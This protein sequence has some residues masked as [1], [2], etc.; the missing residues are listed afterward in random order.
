MSGELNE[1]FLDSQLLQLTLDEKREALANISRRKTNSPAAHSNPLTPVTKSRRNES[2][3]NK[4]QRE[5]LSGDYLPGRG[6]LPSKLLDEELDAIIEEHESDDKKCDHKSF[7]AAP[8]LS[9]LQSTGYGKTRAMVELAKTSDKRVVY[10]LCKSLAQSWR[11]PQVLQKILSDMSVDEATKEEL[12]ERKWLKFIDVVQDLV[13]ASDYTNRGA[14]YNGQITDKWELGQFYEDLLSRWDEATTP[15]KNV[16]RPALKARPSSDSKNSAKK[17]V[18]FDYSKA[19]PIKEGCL[20]LCFD[21]V[22]A[23]NRPAFRAL[24]RAAKQRGALCVF[25]DTAASI[26]QLMN[27]NDHS[28]QVNGGRLGRFVAPIFA[29][30]T[31]DLNWS[32][33]CDEQDYKKLF[34]AGRARWFSHYNMCLKN[35]EDEHSCI[36]SLI[37]LAQKLLL[38]ESGHELIGDDVMYYSCD[39]NRNTN[40]SVPERVLP[41]KIAAFASRFSLGAESRISSLL[42]KHSVATVVGVSEDREIVSCAYP[43]E[44]VLA[45]ASARFTADHED[46]LREVLCHV[47]AAIHGT[48]KLLDPPKGDTGEMCAAALLGYSMDY[49][50]KRSDHQYMSEPVPLSALLDIFYPSK[51][52]AA[53]TQITS[54][55]KDWNVNFTHFDRPNRTPTQ[56]DLLIMWKR[57]LAYYVQEG[58]EGLDLLIAIKKGDSYGTIR[59]QVKNY[60]N[61]ISQGERNNWLYKLLPTKCPPYFDDDPFSVSLLLSVNGIRDC[62][63]IHEPDGTLIYDQSCGRK[64]TLQRLQE[65]RIE[66]ATIEH[67]VL[68]LATCFPCHKDSP[69]CW[70]AEEL[71]SICSLEASKK[72]SKDYFCHTYTAEIMELEDEE[73][74]KL[75][76]A[77]CSSRE[78][79]R[80]HLASN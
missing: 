22:S 68:Q 8:F 61:E 76:A 38:N 55:V 36:D 79:K 9:I 15:K 53:D 29:L 57:R 37:E 13:D 64:R 42:V 35:G 4:S 25:A 17:R 73:T 78:H 66:E 43:S 56:S 26:C 31:G 51:K 39:R 1:Q 30:N 75:E 54:A 70:I 59:V 28:S 77:G 12:Y 2:A 27:P 45:E 71:R 19:A 11:V 50:R 72:V 5:D 32:R 63:R 60:K 24:R 48:N 67:R 41:G 33:K 20:V 46:N 58:A 21:E 80:Q 69:V 44:P 74:K 47:K 10:L 16:L 62:C 34:L 6:K 3:E 18:T 14:L 65:A 7:A 40:E 52:Y 49:I 23:F